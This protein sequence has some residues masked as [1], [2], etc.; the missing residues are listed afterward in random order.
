ML[1][2]GLRKGTLV[3]KTVYTNHLNSVTGADSPKAIR[4]GRNQPALGPKVVVEE[5]VSC[6]Y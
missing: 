6:H 3:F 1:G 5:E 2:M 4:F